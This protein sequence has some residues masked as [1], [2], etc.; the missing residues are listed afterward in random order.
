MSEQQWTAVD[1][2]ITGALL[3][4]DE[5]LDA[6][7][8]ASDAAGLPAIAVSPAQGKLLNLLA[9][10]VNARRILEFGTLGGY[11]TIWLARALPP[12]G[13]LITLEYEPKYAEMARANIARAGLAELV[14]VRVGAALDALPLLMDERE[15]G[16]IELFDLV[17]ID[18]DKEHN[19]D[20]FAASVLLTRPGGVII[21]DNVVR[22][23]DVIDAR[24][25]DSAVQ[26]TRRLIEVVSAEPQVS[27]TAIQTVGTKG[28]DGFAI[29]IVG[30]VNRGA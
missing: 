28:Y 14:D 9:R 1:D 13:L 2:Y 3:G 22:G 19:A 24:S 5:A 17:F 21:V 29:A 25:E 12:D 23:G 4:P 10:M 20:Y 11:S 15:A 30:Q 26:G 16:Q 27:A 18:A 8:V 7:L 6:A